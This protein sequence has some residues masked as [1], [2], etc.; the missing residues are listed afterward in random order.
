MGGK[1]FDTSPKDLFE[2]D[3]AGWARRFCTGPILQAVVIDSEGS[4]I[5]AAADKAL[6]VSQQR[7][8]RPTV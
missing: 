5:T 1:P 8:D 4:T 2:I 6:G 3:P 7:Y